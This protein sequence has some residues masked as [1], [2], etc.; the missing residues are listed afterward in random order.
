MD[1]GAVGSKFHLSIDQTGA[2]ELWVTQA[3]NIDLGEDVSFQDI[4]GAKLIMQNGQ[5]MTKIEPP[6]ENT[7]ENKRY[8]SIM[9]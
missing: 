1:A 8:C 5:N 9:I 7:I 6:K 3:N 2:R 4:L